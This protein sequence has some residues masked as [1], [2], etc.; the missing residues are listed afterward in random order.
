[1]FDKRHEDKAFDL[2]VAPINY[3]NFIRVDAILSNSSN[4]IGNEIYMAGERREEH[5][6]VDE[7]DFWQTDVQGNQ[8]YHHRLPMIRGI[9]CI[10]GCCLVLI[11]I[12]G[13]WNELT[14]HPKDRRKDSSNSRRILSN[15]GRM[16]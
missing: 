16:M 11:L 13:D 14:R 6:N 5:D 15:L 7:L 4:Q 10:L 8:D 3:V 12:R 2:S 9:K 1:V